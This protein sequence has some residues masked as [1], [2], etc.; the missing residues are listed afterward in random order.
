MNPSEKINNRVGLAL[1]PEGTPPTKL[2]MA[3]VKMIGVLYQ[4]WKR[5]P[6]PHHKKMLEGV[7]SDLENALIEIEEEGNQ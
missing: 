2:T 4:I 6:I 3:L 7:F 5:S 1:T